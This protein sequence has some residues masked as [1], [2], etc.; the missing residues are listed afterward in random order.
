MTG[1]REPGADELVQDLNDLGALGER[2]DPIRIVIR[3]QPKWEAIALGIVGLCTLFVFG[4]GLCFLVFAAWWQ[5]AYLV[6]GPSRVTV[7]HA[8]GVSKTY[9]GIPRRLV[10]EIREKV[11]NDPV[12]VR[13]ELPAPGRH[14]RT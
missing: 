4:L 6:W 8:D 1:S 9:R 11:S 13:D 3:P 2:A 5:F 10:R 14:S 12:R 7:H